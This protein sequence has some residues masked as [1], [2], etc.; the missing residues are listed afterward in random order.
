MEPP[1]NI[2][3]CPWKREPGSWDVRWNSTRSSSESH[4]YGINELPIDIVPKRNHPKN[5]KKEA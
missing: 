4:R 5:I 3:A 1:E 2:A